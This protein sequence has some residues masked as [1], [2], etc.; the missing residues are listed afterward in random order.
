MKALLLFPLL[1]FG[2]VYDSPTPQFQPNIEV[3]ALYIL[4]EDK[5][6]L[7]HRQDFKSE[8]DCW[9]VPGGKV[10]KGETPLEAVLRETQ[11]ETGQDFSQTPVK[12]MKTVYIELNEDFH[13]LYHIF[14]ASWPTDP[15]SVKINFLEHKGFTWVTRDQTRNLHLMQDE[16]VCLDFIFHY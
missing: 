1:L 3:S 14:I 16:D 15:A 10:H 4:Y 8:G 7:L 13:V 2:A 11:E 9:G 5:V 6:L 12:H